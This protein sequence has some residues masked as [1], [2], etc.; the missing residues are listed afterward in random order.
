MY[1]KILIILSLTLALFFS[2]CGGK[3]GKDSGSDLMSIAISDCE[4]YTDV[5]TGDIIVE[6]DENTTIKTIFNTDGSR[7]VCIISGTAHIER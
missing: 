2:A 6:D 1:Q 4:D 7:K 3:S 5:L